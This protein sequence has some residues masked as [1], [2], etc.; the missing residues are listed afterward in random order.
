MINSG[1]EWDWMDNEIWDEFNHYCDIYACDDYK[2]GVDI[3]YPH[4]ILDK[5]HHGIYIMRNTAGTIVKIGCTQCIRTRFQT[6]YKHVR[7]TTNDRIR[8]YVRS[9]GTL[10]VSVYDVP[11]YEE[12]ILTHMVRF[13]P[14]HS[15]EKQILDQYARETDG[16]PELNVVRR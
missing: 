7:N 2:Q 9:N 5:G 13:T 4:V 15:L 16:L 10:Q 3:H 14:I 6:M 12:E 8:E 11:T 1:K